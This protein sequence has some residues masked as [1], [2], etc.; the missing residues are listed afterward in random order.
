MVK[1][2]I[3]IKECKGTSLL[4]VKDFLLNLAVRYMCSYSGVARLKI[5]FY[6]SFFIL[7]LRRQKCI[8]Q[9]KWNSHHFPPILYFCHLER[10]VGLSPSHKFV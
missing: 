1:F 8:L 10:K 9:Q 6:G 3:S 5:Y 2:Y 4:K 7:F